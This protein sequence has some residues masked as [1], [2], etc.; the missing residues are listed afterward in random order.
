[1]KLGV[2][3]QTNIVPCTEEE[4]MQTIPQKFSLTQNQSEDV[5]YV[6]VEQTV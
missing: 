4:N 5:R 1:M 6:I 2:Q 3:L